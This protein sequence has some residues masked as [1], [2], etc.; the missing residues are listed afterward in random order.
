MYLVFG[1]ERYYANGGGYDLLLS[2]EDK[3]TAISEASSMIGKQMV[4]EIAEDF[5]DRSFDTY[6]YIEWTH[7]LDTENGEVVETFGERPYSQCKQA[8]EVREAPS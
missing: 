8:I 4:F 3:S 5:E 6:N 1:G 7:V 2:H